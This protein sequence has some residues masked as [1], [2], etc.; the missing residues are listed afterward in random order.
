MLDT[1]KQS[2]ILKP[3]LVLK[4]LK[5]SATT[6]VQEKFSLFTKSLN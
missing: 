4:Y 5:V 1:N 6:S 2:I 3:K